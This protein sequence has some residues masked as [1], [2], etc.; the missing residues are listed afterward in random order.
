VN[1]TKLKRFAMDK[2]IKDN[3]PYISKIKVIQK[4][5]EKRRGNFI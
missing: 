1:I 5:Y 2:F 4:G 3:A